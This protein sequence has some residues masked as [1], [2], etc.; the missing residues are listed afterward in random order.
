MERTATKKLETAA[1]KT[2]RLLRIMERLRKECPWDAKQTHHSLKPYLLEET[3]EVLE[4]IDGEEW[5]KLA[6]ELGDLL[7]Q[8][9]FHSTIAEEEGLFDFAEVAERISNKLIERH[10]HVFGD[11]TI[12]DAKSVQEN[13]EHSKVKNEDRQSIL[14]GVPRAMPALLQAQRLQEKAATVGF[15]WGELQ[16]VIAKIDEEWNEFKTAVEKGNLLNAQEE[17]G[18]VL[19]SMVNISRFIGINAEDALRNTSQKF[20]R[21]FSHIEKQYNSNPQAM[22]EAGLEELDRHWNDAKDVTR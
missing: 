13:W 22:K 3:Y 8:I 7:L 17:F 9:V 4:T 19:F 6:G 1:E 12:H 5:D 21:R 2:A 14:S 18:D 16:P 20:I 15:D 10:P 11:K